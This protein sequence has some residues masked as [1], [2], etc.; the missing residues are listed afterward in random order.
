MLEILQENL[1]SFISFVMK[2]M[3]NLHEK[4]II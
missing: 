4:E 2:A 1:F 3:N